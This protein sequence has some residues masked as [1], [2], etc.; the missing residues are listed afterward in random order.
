[1]GAKY[2]M[3]RP[4]PSDYWVFFRDGYVWYTYCVPLTLIYYTSEMTEH[5]ERWALI[6]G[7]S[8]GG[9][10]DALVQEFLSNNVKVIATAP[11]LA[12]LEHLPLEDDRIARIELDVTSASSIASAAARTNSITNG[13]L[14]YLINIA[15]YGYMMP[16]MDTAPDAVKANF[17]VNV[18]ALLTVTQQ[19]LPM[20][21]RSKGT[22]ANQ[23]SI[24]GLRA[25][26]QPFIGVYSATKAAAI[27]LSDTMRL[28]LKPF[29]IKVNHQ[30]WFSASTNADRG[31][32]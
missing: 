16:L 10:G 26:R 6:T 5:R 7:V 8:P 3:C 1:M 24:A 30:A 14:D 20:L 32:W 27:S 22:V 21:A 15:G 28:E 2:V 4:C 9:L 25:G 12:Q 18:F 13:K 31:R 19:L 23:C 29:G 11:T 17:D